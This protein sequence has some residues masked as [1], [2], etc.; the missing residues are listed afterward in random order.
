M[1]DIVKIHNFIHPDHE[2]NPPIIQL[3]LDG[4]MESKSSTNSL[5]TFSLTFNHC[6]NIYPIALIRPCNRYKYDEQMALK[7]ILDD[8]NAN[9][10][11]ID[12]VVLD[13]PK[14]ATVLCSKGACAKFACEYCESCAV[15]YNVNDKANKA[16]EK[17]Y[18]AQTRRLSQQLLR[19]E[20]NNENSSENEE[21]I[22]LRERISHLKSEKNK[23]IKK[24]KKQLTWPYSTMN[25]EVRTIDN[26][27]EIANAIENDP[28]ILKNNPDYCKGIKGKSLLLD[29]PFFHIIKDAP[30][31]YMHTVCICAGRRLL[32]LTFKVG[33][34]R[35]RLTKRKLSLPKTFNDKIKSVQLP[36]ESSRRCRN[37]DLGVMK[38]A[39]L[40]N[41]IIFFFPII[42]DCIEDDFPKEKKIWLHFAF[43]IRAC[44][45]SN[46]E[47]RNVDVDDVKSASKKFYQ[48]YEQAFGK[49]NCS[50]SIHVVASHILPIRGNRPL[51]HKS[52]F[53]FESFYSEMR[54]LFKPGTV[55]PLKQILQNS[56]V[57]RLLEYHCCEKTTFFNVQKKPKEGKK[58][59]PPKERNDL[60]YTLN[61]NY[62]I[63][64]F[65]IVEIIDDDHFRCHVQGRF[66]LKL[67]LTPEYDWSNVGVF[68]LGPISEELHVIKRNDI[69]GK[70]IQVNN[71]LITCPNNVLH[72]Q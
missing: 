8:I 22:D 44:V 50:Y 72:E 15:S 1:A 65:V 35:E 69:R 25:G 18:E 40:R 30:A 34:N 12:S 53:K 21:I 58:F 70:V 7:Q 64:M 28:D 27:R 6:R 67:S 32:E 61:E 23:K 71:Y 5:D 17:R 57:K 48:L 11:I 47:F 4:V 2:K 20:D 55:S 59:N 24:V 45:L 39:E 54:N 37:M 49:R 16:V 26:I 36:R 68:K 63:S 52:A 56:F 43:M 29:Q 3:S 66:K 13:K 10:V 46:D 19:L 41:C 42:V 60:I 31:E 33:E 14:R 9:N 51:T 62:D 38:A